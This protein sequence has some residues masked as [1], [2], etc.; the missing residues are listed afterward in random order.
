MIKNFRLVNDI[1]NLFKDAS[2]DFFN[3]YEWYSNY[4]DTVVSIDQDEYSFVCIFSDEDD[5][6]AV[7]PIKIKNQSNRL[8]VFSLTNYYSPLYKIIIK[9]D[10]PK[11]LNEFIDYLSDI[12]PKWGVLTLESLDKIECDKIGKSVSFLKYPSYCA[13]HFYNWYLPVLGRSYSEYYSG[14]S[15]RVRNTIKRK[16]KAIEKIDDT[17]IMIYKTP[18]EVD[19]GTF[20]FQ[21]VYYK[22]WKKPEPYPGF[23]PGLIGMAAR[24]GVL[25]LG[26]FYIGDNP[27]AAQIW[28]VADKTA[29]IFKLAYKEDYKKISP[30]TILTAHLMRYVI[31][32]DKVDIVDFLSGDD[33]YKK[34]WMSSRRERYLLHIY[35]VKSLN[36]IKL[37]LLSS[38]KVI[39]LRIKS[40]FKVLKKISFN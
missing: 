1:E 5:D 25:R 9:T 34:D 23:I 37:M 10:F 18:E 13:S 40:I 20:D 15:D 8:S 16:T 6:F 26:I 39:I 31:D 11:K 4:V 24:Q 7:I 36:G 29:Y 28:I 14:L 17:K 30:G 2:C 21:S 27:I 19:S 35:N 38:I 32:V 22:S 3:N 33:E 12:A